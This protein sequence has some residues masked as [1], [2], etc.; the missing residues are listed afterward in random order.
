MRADRLL[1]ILLLLQARG[2]MT[3]QELA[4]HLEVSERTIYR[5]LQALSLAGIPVY[6]ESGIGGGYS[7]I[8]QYQTRL[9]GFTKSE[10]RALAPSQSFGPLHDLGLGPAL[11][12]AFLKLEVVLSPHWHGDIDTVKRSIYL[13]STGWLWAKEPVP[14]LPLLHEALWLGQ[15]VAIDYHRHDGQIRQRVVDP[16]GFVAKSTV[17]YLIGAVDGQIRMFRV[18]RVGA[19]RLLAETSQRPQDFDVRVYWETWNRTFATN[20]TPYIV[21]LRLAP[22][23]MQRLFEIADE[24]ARSSLREEPLSDDQGWSLVSMTFSSL[25]HA[26]TVAMGVGNLLEVVEPLELRGAIRTQA[27]QIVALYE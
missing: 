11:E 7:L 16:Y 3:A 20:Y 1:T 22:G 9:T 2:R 27:Q 17:W 19:A 15:K 26:R 4:G 23:G 24:T 13:D 18:S 12:A 10:V 6:A 8:E 25:L 21:R 14:F 5:D